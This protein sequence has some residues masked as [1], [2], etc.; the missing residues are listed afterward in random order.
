MSQGG[1]GFCHTLQTNTQ[2][3]KQTNKYT[4]WH[5]DSAPAPSG[6]GPSENLSQ[7]VGRNPEEFNF[8][9]L[10]FHRKDGKKGMMEKFHKNGWAHAFS[11]IFFPKKRKN[12][13]FPIF[14]I[15]D[16]VFKVEFLWVSTTESAQIFFHVCQLYIPYFQTTC[17][18][19]TWARA[20]AFLWK[21][22]PKKTIKKYLFSHA[23]SVS[24]KFCIGGVRA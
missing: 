6:G 19:C 22:V 10:V 2:N 12:T 17:P 8:E 16:Q 11:W 21:N 7:F 15:K 20:R 4:M 1:D 5:K 18:I 13:F 14:S 23:T 3:Q 9:N 24:P